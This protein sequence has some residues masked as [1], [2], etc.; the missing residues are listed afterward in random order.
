MANFYLKCSFYCKGSRAIR[1]STNHPKS[2]FALSREGWP[3]TWHATTWDDG[4]R[5]TEKT[6]FRFQLPEP[7]RRLRDITKRG[8]TYMSWAWAR[9]NQK[10][11]S[12]VLKPPQSRSKVGCNAQLGHSH[13]CHRGTFWES[14]SWDLFHPPSPPKRSTENFT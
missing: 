12:T 14:L 6:K 9:T 10:R 11:W 1:C 2:I 4:S 13:Q 8:V 5:V 3:N 7:P